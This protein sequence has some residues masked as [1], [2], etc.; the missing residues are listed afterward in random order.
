MAPDIKT[1]E[2]LV[3]I[4]TREV[5]LAM[6]EQEEEQ[7]NPDGRHLRGGSCQRGKSENLL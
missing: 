3:E 6:V 4:I 7:K 5:L 2:T 1:V